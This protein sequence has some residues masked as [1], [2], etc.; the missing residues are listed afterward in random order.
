MSTFDIQMKNIFSLFIIYFLFSI[1]LSFAKKEESDTISIRNF[2]SGLSVDD[3]W[4]Y[5]TGDDRSW[6][7]INFDDKEWRIY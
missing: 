6:A 2:K 5:K 3:L 1:S 7:A 4:K